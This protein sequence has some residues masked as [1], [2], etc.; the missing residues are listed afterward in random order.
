ML[1]II[2]LIFLCRMNGTLA[3]KKGLKPGVWKA[4]TV[5]AWIGAELAGFMIAL[6]MFDKTELFAIM[7][8][9]IFCAFGGYLAVKYTLEQKPDGVD[10][11]VNEIGIDD[12]RPPKK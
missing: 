10:N 12:L 3:A 11:D 5:L 6:T 4:Y 7:G 1:E 2:A 9:G 8:V